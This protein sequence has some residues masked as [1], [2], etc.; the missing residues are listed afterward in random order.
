MPRGV[1]YECKMLLPNDEVMELTN[2]PMSELCEKINN[3]FK[4]K[5]YMDSVT[6][7]HQILYNLMK[8]PNCCSKLLKSKLSVKKINKESIVKI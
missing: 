4:E 3:N 5:Y 6:V 8:R 2:V 1:R 7:N